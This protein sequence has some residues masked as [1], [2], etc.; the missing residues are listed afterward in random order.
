MKLRDLATLVT[1]YAADSDEHR[2]SQFE[3]PGYGAYRRHERPAIQQSIDTAY[4]A[5]TS[6][7]NCANPNPAESFS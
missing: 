1:S 5:F 6:N 3:R 7:K 4:E 2:R